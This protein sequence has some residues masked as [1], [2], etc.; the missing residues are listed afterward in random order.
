[1]EMDS[2]KI[3]ILQAI[4]DYYIN[5]AEPVGSRTIAKKYNM[6]ISS[7]TIRNEMADLEDM[8]Y[9]EQLHSSSGRKPSNKGYR[10]Y[11]DKLMEIPILSEAELYV[12]KKQIL[13]S[14]L[15]EVDKIIKQ[16]TLL[17]AQLTKLTCI[18]RTPSVSKSYIKHLQLVNIESN[19]NILLVLVTDSGVIKTM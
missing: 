2:R 17:L 7:A 11:V 9:L 3:K 10:L 13:N 18:V 15:F 4:I 12:I 19:S 16:A 14:A 5:T 6:G 1:M 8:G